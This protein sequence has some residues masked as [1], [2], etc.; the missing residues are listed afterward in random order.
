M[1]SKLAANSTQGK[2]ETDTFWDANQP[3]FGPG[4]SLRY[5]LSISM[6]IQRIEP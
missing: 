4:I 2:K 1:I 5:N 6:G 3:G